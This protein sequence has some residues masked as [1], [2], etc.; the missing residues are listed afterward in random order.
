MLVF[1]KNIYGQ[2]SYTGSVPGSVGLKL[3][4][5]KTKEDASQ[6][7]SNIII[8]LAK[9]A[10]A[11]KKPLSMIVPTGN[12]PVLTYKICVDEYK[13]GNVSFAYV[14]FRS[15]DEYEGMTKYHDFM[16][17]H[18]IDAIDCHSYDIFNGK[19][20]DPESE[21][22]R[23]EN[24]IDTENL[25]L[26]FG[27]TGEE[28]HLAFNEAAPTLQT[29]CHREKLSDSTKS[30]N[31]SDFPADAFPDYAFT[32]GLQVM[33]KAKKAMIYAFG[34]KKIAA[35]QKAVS[36]VIDPQAP[37]SF[38]QLMQDADLIMD[39]TAATELIKSGMVKPV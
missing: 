38:I 36:G 13:A 2:P 1:D 26:L 22:R 15:M 18:F 30:A 4:V 39:E 12:S 27:G 21:C 5:Y 10:H 34:E 29:A 32:I 11:S 17:H 19:A 28:G 16:T 31:A 35:V 3:Y 7:G 9:K 37:I 24:N 25:A 33:F 6:A 14:N 23:Y 20:A 8:N